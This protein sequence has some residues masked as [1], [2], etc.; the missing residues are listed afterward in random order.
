MKFCVCQKIGGFNLTVLQRIEN[1]VVSFYQPGACS[2]SAK[3]AASRIGTHAGFEPMP[4]FEELLVSRDTFY[5]S[6]SIL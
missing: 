5:M 4:C 3:M 6:I 1:Y 2:I